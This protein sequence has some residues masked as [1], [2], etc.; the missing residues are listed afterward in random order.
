MIKIDFSFDTK[1]GT[2]GDALVLSEDHGLSD[3]DLENMKQQR[4][5]N[6][7]AIVETPSE[8]IDG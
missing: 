5:A 6:W 3:T 1:Y 7:I 2:F 8:P 4:L